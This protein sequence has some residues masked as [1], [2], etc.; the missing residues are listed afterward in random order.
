ME[1]QGLD[2]ATILCYGI[3]FYLY[4]IVTDSKKEKGILSLK[5]SK[6]ERK[7]D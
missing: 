1:I 3:L 4:Q 6:H 5:V 2:V 7:W